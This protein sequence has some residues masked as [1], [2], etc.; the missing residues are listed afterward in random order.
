MPCHFLKIPTELRF[1][2]Y[3]FLLPDRLVPARFSSSEDLR[4]DNQGCYPQI[5]RLNHQIHDEAASVLYGQ[6]TFEIEVSGGTNI[7]MCNMQ[8]TFESFFT[9]GHPPRLG[10]NAHSNPASFVNS[11]SIGSH[12]QQSYQMQLMLLEQQNKKRLLMARQEQ[13]NISR[14]G[15]TPSTPKTSLS[16]TASG[17]SSSSRDDAGSSKGNQDLVDIDSSSTP[18]IW[19]PEHVCPTYFDLIR[20]FSIKI[21]FPIVSMPPPPRLTPRCGPSPA[22]LRRHFAQSMMY[23]HPPLLITRQGWHEHQLEKVEYETCDA[24]NQLVGRLKTMPQPIN[25]LSVSI[26]VDQYDERDEAL[27][28]SQLFLRPFRR[29]R[30]IGTPTVDSVRWTD[31]LHR[32]H[33]LFPTGL[34]A[35][36]ERS[37]AA[38]ITRWKADVS[39]SGPAPD[40]SPVVNAYW[41]LHRVIVDIYSHPE[42]AMVMVGHQSLQ[43][44]LLKA[45]VAREAEDM[46]EL[47]STTKE[48][49]VIWR[50][51]LYKQKR[52]EERVK[53]RV[54]F[55]EGLLGEETMTDV[56][57]PAT[58]ECEGKGKGKAVDKNDKEEEE[59]TWNDDD[60]TRYVKKNGDV[61]VQLLTPALVRGAPSWFYFKI[62]LT[63]TFQVKQIKKETGKQL[64]AGVNPQTIMLNPQ[65]APPPPPPLHHSLAIQQQHQFFLQRQQLSQ[66]HAQMQ[67]QQAATVQGTVNGS[68]MQQQALQQHQVTPQQALQQQQALQHQ[69][70]QQALQY[71]QQ[72]QA[73]Q[74]QQVLQQQQQHALRQQQALQLQ[75]S[76]QQQQ[77]Y[78]LTSEEEDELDVCQ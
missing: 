20:S 48:V 33:N 71:Q 47:K 13:R 53:R 61:R 27:A 22:A 42:V 52:F 69:Q 57:F 43:D 78:P 29:L 6:T 7:F 56:H 35:P 65:A 60:G 30:D 55:V 70:Q 39:S 36:L 54:D 58:L 1:R 37:F 38:Y 34:V 76:Q 11:T 46:V 66:Q 31:G 45:K 75:V 68:A 18:P 63:N 41:V 2:I 64:E 8:R 25:R 9:H 17:P 62:G 32:P 59:I 28:A 19:T 67:A 21:L 4:W 26:T 77:P 24:L 12:P 10:M 49:G 14:A 16:S 73:L 50:K 74:H 5:L 15:P 3:S 51:Y 23:T 44:L 40:I 72:Q